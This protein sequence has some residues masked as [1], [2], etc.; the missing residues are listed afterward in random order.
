MNFSLAIRNTRAQAIINAID[1]GATPGTISFYTAPKP[2]TG[3]EAVTTQTLLGTLTLSQPCG[4]VLNG[5]LVF[6][7]I[8]DDA[9][10]DNTGVIAWARVLDGDGTF[11]LDAACGVTGSG[12]PIE[13][14]SLNTIAGGLIE[15]SSAKIIEGNV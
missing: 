13:L 1:A 3:G 5:E 11:C 12:S 8:A 6:N 4:S 14:P 9:A 7:A 15:M 10:A 2:A